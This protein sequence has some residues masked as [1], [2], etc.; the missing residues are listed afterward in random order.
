MVSEISHASGRRRRGGT[1]FGATPGI[2]YVIRAM[3]LTAVSIM[4][5]RLR[6]SR[7]CLAPGLFFKSSLTGY[8]AISSSPCSKVLLVAVA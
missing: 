7:P 4:T 1:C 3:E 6:G 5:A 8:D 2:A